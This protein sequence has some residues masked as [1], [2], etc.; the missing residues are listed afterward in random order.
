MGRGREGGGREGRKG[1]GGGRES[2]GRMDAL[3][4][5]VKEGRLTYMIILLSSADS[6]YVVF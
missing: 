1:E 3:V 2:E 4:D 5:M 6:C